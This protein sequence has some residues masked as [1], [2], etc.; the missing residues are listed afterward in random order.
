MRNEWIIRQK[1]VKGFEER[2]HQIVKFIE[3]TT[4]KISRNKLS[5]EEILE[6]NNQINGL[7]QEYDTITITKYITAISPKLGD[8]PHTDNKIIQKYYDN[9]KYNSKNDFFRE[10]FNKYFCEFSIED[11][12]GY[13]NYLGETFLDFKGYMIANSSVLSAEIQII[14]SQ[15][16]NPNVM[17]SLANMI[18]FEIK[19]MPNSN[20]KFLFEKSIR[21]LRFWANQGHSI[22]VLLD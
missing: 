9:S 12:I 17:L 21:W 19:N 14:G 16:M 10:N 7:L 20:S 4:E 2:C 18:E 6:L 22:R 13:T 8:N 5:N 3:N 11:S 15:D 1:P